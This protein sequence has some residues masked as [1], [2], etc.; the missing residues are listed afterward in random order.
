MIF[1]KDKEQKFWV[2]LSLL[3]DG[4][5][6]PVFCLLF[7]ITQPAEEMVDSG[8]NLSKVD[9]LSNVRLKLSSQ[10]PALL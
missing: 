9:P 5:L 10:F 2:I 8:D 6:P 3:L 7:E 4:H 1:S